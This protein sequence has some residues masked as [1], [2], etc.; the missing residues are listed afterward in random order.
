MYK[1]IKLIFLFAIIENDE[2]EVEE[3]VDKMGH[4][5]NKKL[6]IYRMLNN[7]LQEFKKYL[8]EEEEVHNQTVNKGAGAFGNIRR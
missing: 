4:I 8:R 3:Y 6:E 1:V 5:I 7:K 2:Y